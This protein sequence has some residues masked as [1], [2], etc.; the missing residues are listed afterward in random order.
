MIGDCLAA[1]V[2]SPVLVVG[3]FVLKGFTSVKNGCRCLDV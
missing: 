1:G 3:S 2:L